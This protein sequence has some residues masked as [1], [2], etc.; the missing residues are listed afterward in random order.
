VLTEC[1]LYILNHISDHSSYQCSAYFFD[2]VDRI[3]SIL[4][5]YWLLVLYLVSFSM[6]KCD[7]RS[8]VELIHDCFNYLCIEKCADH[9]I[10]LALKICS[11]YEAWKQLKRRLYFLQKQKLTDPSRSSRRVVFELTWILYF[12]SVRILRVK[13][14]VPCRLGI[15]YMQISSQDKEQD[16]H[17][18][19]AVYSVAP[20]IFSLSRWTLTLSHVIWLRCCH[21]SHNPQR[22]VGH[23]NKERL[24]CPSHTVRLVCL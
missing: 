13:V 22:A 9:F 2:T 21:V 16:M 4:F 12:F 17:P 24:S 3:H 15:L 18:C 10:M 6:E 11:G 8:K 23:R 5:S 19:A 7:L 1:I 20:C 14:S